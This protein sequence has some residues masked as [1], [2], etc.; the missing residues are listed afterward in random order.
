M[1]DSKISV[2]YAKALFKAAIEADLLLQVMKDMQLIMNVYALDNFRDVLESPVVK[3]SEKKKVVE[4]LFSG[5]I[6]ELSMTFFNLM[7][8]NKRE[9]H[10][11]HIARNFKSFYKQNEGILSAQI[12]I[13]E[14]IDEV[15]TNN[16]RSL[17]KNAFNSEIELEALVKPD[18]LGGFILRIEDEQFDASVAS[19][20][21]KI[22]RQL[23]EPNL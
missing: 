2:R 13:S 1:N 23:L 4:K 17:L 22:K 15:Q 7:L 9:S 12:V 19:S 20:L 6:C 11:P 14:P 10:L 8:S 16:F 3:T 21:T 5:K 18:I